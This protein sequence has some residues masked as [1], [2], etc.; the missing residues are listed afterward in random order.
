MGDYSRIYRRWKK[1]KKQFAKYRK[2]IA[3]CC[4]NRL[5]VVIFA[6][7]ISEMAIGLLLFSEI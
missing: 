4:Q 5:S 1:A 6:E 3:V 2:C 7:G